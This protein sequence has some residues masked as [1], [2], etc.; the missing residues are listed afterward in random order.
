MQ[1]VW[2]ELSELKGVGGASLPLFVNRLHT[3]LQCEMAVLKQE[4]GKYKAGYK[5]H[6]FLLSSG[7]RGVK[8]QGIWAT[9]MKL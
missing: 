4:L 3:M 2:W 7:Y 9:L 5:G 8:Y 1:S 6:Q